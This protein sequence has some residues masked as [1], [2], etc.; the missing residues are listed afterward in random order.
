LFF[1]T[2]RSGKARLI[3]NDLKKT[4]EETFSDGFALL[5]AYFDALLLTGPDGGSIFTGN[6][7]DPSSG[8]LAQQVY[9]LIYLGRTG[10]RKRLRGKMLRL[11]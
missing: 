6:A 5:V 11:S 7:T 8:T 9:E 10:A 3:A 4:H 1:A 2:F